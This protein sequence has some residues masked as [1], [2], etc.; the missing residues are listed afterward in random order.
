MPSPVFQLSSKT[1][2]LGTISLVL[3]IGIKLHPC[4]NQI[5]AV[6]FSVLAISLFF[7]SVPIRS[8][9]DFQ[10]LMRSHSLQCFAG[11]SCSHA[12]SRWSSDLVSKEQIVR[13]LCEVFT[14]EISHASLARSAL[15]QSYLWPIADDWDTVVK[16]PSCWLGL[17]IPKQHRTTRCTCMAIWKECFNELFR[18]AS[19]PVLIPLEETTQALCIISHLQEC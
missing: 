11:V 13:V 5:E 19:S 9:F 6:N 12:Q 8:W 7:L 1:V 3:Y 18:V 4:S 14:A 2:G 16:L 10:L 17:V 15:P